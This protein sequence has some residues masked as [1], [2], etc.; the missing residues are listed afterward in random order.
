MWNKN[1]PLWYSKIETKSSVI[2]L[3]LSFFKIYWNTEIKDDLNKESNGLLREE[4]LMI[5]PLLSGLEAKKI[6]HKKTECVWSNSS[7]TNEHHN[8]KGWLIRKKM[9]SDL[10]TW[11]WHKHL[12]T[13]YEGLTLHIRWI[14]P[15]KTQ[16]LCCYVWLSKT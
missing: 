9:F 13:H 16:T 6:F 7:G 4:R 5:Q 1:A 2:L 11:I 14:I 8:S 10:M 15:F 3:Q 12:Q